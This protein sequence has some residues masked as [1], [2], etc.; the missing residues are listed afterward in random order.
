MK[1]SSPVLLP[2]LRSKTQGD[3][4]ARLFLEPAQEPSISELAEQVGVS[5]SQ[6]LREV[7]R[8]EDAGLVSTRRRGHSRL[9][10]VHT[11]NPVYA[12]LAELLAV[13]FG[14]VPVLERLF[15]PIDGIE[16]AFIFGSWAAR[17]ADQPGP[18]PGDIDVMVIGPV[19]RDLLYDL[20]TKAGRTLHREV[21]IRR[22][23][24]NVW[25]QSENAAFRT[26]VE[27]RPIVRLIERQS[28][29]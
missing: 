9:I 10:T 5:P 2:L 1:V 6:T 17:Y 26:T 14:A 19:D 29:R 11:D 25:D 12:P 20:G 23:T 27:S 13:T 28:D 21:N 18:V 24:R 22:M 16:E 8:L 15:E 3:I 7:N 4:F